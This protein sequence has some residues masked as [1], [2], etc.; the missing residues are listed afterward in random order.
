VIQRSNRGVLSSPAVIR[1]AAV[2]FFCIPG[3]TDAHAAK[4][5]S[6]ESTEVGLASFYS[7][8]F[9][10]RQTA[11]GETFDNDDMVAAH[12]T[13]PLDTMVRVT[14]LEKPH[15]VVVRI[16]DRGPSVENQNEGVIID[17]SQA[18]A[19]TLRMRKDGR[20]R[21]RVDVLKWGEREKKPLVERT[22][23]SHPAAQNAAR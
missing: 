20:V 15:S 18:A 21:V 7:R 17:L 2:L 23:R 19:S 11:G 5:H 6:P 12:P 1:I 14:N 22:S 10:G 16:S 13:Y 9:D 3:W 8:A 4:R